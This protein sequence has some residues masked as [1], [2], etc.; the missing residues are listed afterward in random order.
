[1][2]KEMTNIGIAFEI[3]ENDM[4]TLCGW[5]KVTGHIIFDVKMDFMRKTIWVLDGHKTPDSVGSIYV[6]VISR[7]IVRISF[8]YA[9]LNNLDV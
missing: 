8:T 7:E 9:A 2:R 3:P 4:K 5:T 1:M 6:G